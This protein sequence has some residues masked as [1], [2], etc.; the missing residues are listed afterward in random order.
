MTSSINKTRRLRA[1]IYGRAGGAEREAPQLIWFVECCCSLL[2]SSTR[3]LVCACVVCK[4]KI[5]RNTLCG[6]YASRSCNLE[7]APSYWRAAAADEKAAAQLISLIRH[8][9]R[10]HCGGGGGG[11]FKFGELKQ[12]KELQGSFNLAAAQKRRL[13]KMTHSTLRDDAKRATPCNLSTSLACA[14]ANDDKL[15]CCAIGRNVAAE[16][17]SLTRL[18]CNVS[19]RLICGGARPH[20]SRDRQSKGGLN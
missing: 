14:G 1:I 12:L 7:A 9:L 17:P 18:A 15:A 4:R 2:D 10:C 11:L 19:S 20:A 3:R 6:G 8:R 16:A 13:K 5:G